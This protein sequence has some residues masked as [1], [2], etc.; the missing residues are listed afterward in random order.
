MVDVKGNFLVFRCQMVEALISV[1]KTQGEKALCKHF[2]KQY[3]P[4]LEHGGKAGLAGPV[5]H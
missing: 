2:K 5:L 1:G 4:R 3:K